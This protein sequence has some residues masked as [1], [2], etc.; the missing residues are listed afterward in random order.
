MHGPRIGILVMG[1]L[2]LRLCGVAVAGV[3]KVVLIEEFTAVW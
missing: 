2:A 3:P 1:L